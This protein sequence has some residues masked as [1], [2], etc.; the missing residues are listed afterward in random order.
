MNDINYNF[1]KSLKLSINSSFFIDERLQYDD[2][3]QTIKF[4]TLTEPEKICLYRF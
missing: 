3:D 1:K 2:Q 4:L